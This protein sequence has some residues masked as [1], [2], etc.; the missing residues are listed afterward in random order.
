VVFRYVNRE[1]EPD[2]AA[3]PNGSLGAIAGI[4]SDRGN[5]LGM[6]PHPERAVE[7]VLGSSDGLAL[8]ESMLSRVSA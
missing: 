7:K 1:G 2:V 4:V 6:M 5:V 3:N 8:F